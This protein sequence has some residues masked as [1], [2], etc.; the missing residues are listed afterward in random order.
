MDS[1]DSQTSVTAVLAEAGGGD[2]RGVLDRLLPIVYQEL[3]TIAR[4]YLGREHRRGT[5]QTTALVHEA[6]LKLVDE[7]R[8][9]LR[10]RAYFFAAVARAMRQILVDAARRR[11]RIKRGSGAAGEPLPE[12]VP[13]PRADAFAGDLLEVHDALARLERQHSRAAAVVEC[14]YFGGLSVE[15]TAAALACSPR[16]VKRDWAFARAWLFR[17]LRGDA[18]G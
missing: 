16:S 5:L 10:S 18:E 1:T 4:A 15:Q 12:V 14:R 7:N 3:R 11:R 2:D 9:P 8:V 6:Y 17:E 13:D